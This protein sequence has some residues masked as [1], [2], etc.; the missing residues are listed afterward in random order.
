MVEPASSSHSPTLTSTSLILRIQAGEAFA[1][2]RFTRLYGPLIYSWCRR[3]G[4]QPSDAEDVSQNVVRAVLKSVGRYERTGSFRS[5]LGQITRSKIIDHFRQHK[6]Q[7]H[8]IGGSDFARQVGELPDQF[9]QDLSGSRLGPDPVLFHALEMIK[10]DF[11][12]ATWTAFWRM[13]VEG[14][15]AAEIAEDLG[16][17]DGTTTGRTKGTGRVRQAKMRIMT[18]LRDE[19]GDLLDLSS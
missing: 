1:W 2:E 8:G 4:L 14:H 6:R 13:T 16:W 19:F 12:P 17:S 11:E 9:S 3:A 7:F 18:R 5:W 15:S 10:A